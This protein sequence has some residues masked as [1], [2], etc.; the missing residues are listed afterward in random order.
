MSRLLFQDA[1][2]VFREKEA[3]GR[4]SS[5]CLVIGLSTAAWICRKVAQATPS[6]RALGDGNELQ[7]D[8]Q[9]DQSIWQKQQQGV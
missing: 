1:Q 9:G 3:M 4:N 2:C 7:A 8:L 6:F 5:Q